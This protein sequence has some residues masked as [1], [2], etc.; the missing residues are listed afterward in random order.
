MSSDHCRMHT[1][2]QFV[3]SALEEVNFLFYGQDK[4]ENED[5]NADE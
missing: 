5:L 1:G 3:I 2:N 4:P